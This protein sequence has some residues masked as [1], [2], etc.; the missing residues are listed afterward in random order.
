GRSYQVV[1]VMPKEFGYPHKSDLRYANGQIETTQLWVPYALTPQQ[2][3]DREESSGFAVARLKPGV[4]MG[5]AQAEMGPIM[6][7]LNLL[8][9]P[10]SRGWYAV[11][12][13]FRD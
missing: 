8:H 9:N 6:S 12:R 5:Q 1:G 10:K 13:S 2:I 7:R 3:A 11:V 4:T